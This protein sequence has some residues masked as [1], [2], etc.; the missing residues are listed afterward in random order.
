MVAE[1]VLGRS[2]GVM[3]L[4]QPGGSVGLAVEVNLVGAQECDPSVCLD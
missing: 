1:G 3:M 4:R 2:V